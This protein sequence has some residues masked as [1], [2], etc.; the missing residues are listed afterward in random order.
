M[1]T[2]F[3]SNI[4]NTTTNVY[5]NN[6]VIEKYDSLY[7]TIEE[8][9]TKKDVQ[10]FA[11]S[12][13]KNVTFMHN[14]PK[15]ELLCI[16]VDK[17]E[18]LSSQLE[19]ILEGLSNYH[20]FLLISVV[21]NDQ[22]IIIQ[23]FSPYVEPKYF[24]DN[25]RKIVFLLDSSCSLKELKEVNVD[26][27]YTIEF[28]P[29]VEQIDEDSVKRLTPTVPQPFFPQYPQCPQYPQPWNP[30]RQPWTI[31][32]PPFRNPISVEPDWTCRPGQ[33]IY[34]SYCSPNQ[35]TVKSTNY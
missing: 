6:G 13:A 8:L 11:Y 4:A 15:K 12:F 29:D 9:L 25:V 22:D 20:N 3:T 31:G 24:V 16:T 19:Y 18:N 26:D 5:F 17:I 35:L 21:S 14:R 10:T 7:R 27:S 1:N 33:I 34:G 23:I 28:L 32:D 2:K 30:L